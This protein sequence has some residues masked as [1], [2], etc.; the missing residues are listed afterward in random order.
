MRTSCTPAFAGYGPLTASKVPQPRR[1]SRA[2]ER[3]GASRPDRHER[4]AADDQPDRK[5][6][7]QADY[8]KARAEAEHVAQR[9]T[10]EPMAC[11]VPQHRRTRVSEAAQHPGRGPLKPIEQLKHSAYEQEGHTDGHNRRVARERADQ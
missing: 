7:P 11:Q 8:P 3:P 2:H 10:D 9:Q 1:S 5:T 6:P 4:D